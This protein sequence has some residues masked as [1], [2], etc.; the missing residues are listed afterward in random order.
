MA[1]AAQAG[2]T[3]RDYAIGA[4]VALG[5]HA[6]LGFSLAIAPPGSTGH[7]PPPAVEKEG[8][9]SVVSPACLGC[10]PMAP[11][12]GDAKAEEEATVVGD[13]RCL[14]PLRRGQRREHEPAPSVAVDL[15][16]AQV[17]ANL[18]VET[19][20]PR[21]DVGNRAGWGGSQAPRP[22]AKLAEA[23][24]G[25]DKLGQLLKEDGGGEDRKR[26]LGDIL[27]LPTGQKH[28]DGKV[29]MP[30][31]A[32]V[33]EVKLAVTARFVLPPSVP[34]WERAGLIAKIR[35]TRM[36]ATGQV[37]TYS[38]EKKSGNDDFDET[39]AG[40]MQGYK[41]GVRSLPPPPPHLLEEI[42]SRGIVIELRGGR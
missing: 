29:N 36:T 26:K 33:R 11:T 32:Y 9:A 20:K 27:G 24:S 13:R 18:G 10:A 5:V 31:S 37:L 2:L 34:V 6:L 14:E 3:G 4:G 16:Q 39:V 30:G 28:G 38:V 42:N 15:L 23:L 1:H 40:L 25:D 7:R 19:G 22:S 8:C 12:V 41:A 35:I 17:I 21:Q